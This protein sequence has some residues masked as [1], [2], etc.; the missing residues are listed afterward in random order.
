MPSYKTAR[1]SFRQT[2]LGEDPRERA[3]VVDAVETSGLPVV[4]A[5]RRPVGWLGQTEALRALAPA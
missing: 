5:E 4:D 3:D 2:R 1:R